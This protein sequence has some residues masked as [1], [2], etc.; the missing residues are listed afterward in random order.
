M[1]HANQN[2]ITTT[3]LQRYRPHKLCS[4]HV[5]PDPPLRFVQV[6]ICF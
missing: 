3:K 6:Q 4:T 5:T 1:S 2:I